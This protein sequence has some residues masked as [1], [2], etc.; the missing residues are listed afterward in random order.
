M[1][2]GRLTIPTPQRTWGEKNGDRWTIVGD[3]PSSIG[4][5]LY[6]LRAVKGWLDFTTNPDN[7]QP[8]E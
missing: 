3:G 2:D 1:D 6:T 5:P 8:M 7:K 4:Y